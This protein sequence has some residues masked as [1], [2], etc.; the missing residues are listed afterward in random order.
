MSGER[1]RSDSVSVPSK[2]EGGRRWV[3]SQR[4]VDMNAGTNENGSRV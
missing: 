2:R 4:L 3:T 1:G